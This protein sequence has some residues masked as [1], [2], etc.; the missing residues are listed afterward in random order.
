MVRPAYGRRAGRSES[1]GRPH[2]IL[3]I[4]ERTPHDPLEQPWVGEME[5]RSNGGGRIPVA[6]RADPVPAQDG[7]NL[8]Y[9]L[10]ITDLTSRRELEAARLRLSR[11]MGEAEGSEAQER[12]Q[13]ELNQVIDAIMRNARMAVMHIHANETDT[14]HSLAIRDVEALTRRASDLTRQMVAFASRRRQPR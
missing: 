8:G 9:I 11:A 4:S 5:L 10:M 6:L 3:R 7:G 1:L 2:E 14:P 12:A 13:G